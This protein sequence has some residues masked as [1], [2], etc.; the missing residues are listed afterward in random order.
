[1]LISV[2]PKALW[3]R[4]TRHAGLVDPSPP[5]AVLDRQD[6][7]SPD[8]MAG[9]IASFDDR[10]TLT[11]SWRRR[12]WRGPTCATCRRCSTSPSLRDGRAVTEVDDHAGGIRGV[13][14]MPYRFSAA[15]SDVRGPAPRR[16]EHN[17]AMLADWL[18]ASAAEV[19]ALLETGPLR[20]A[21]GI[22]P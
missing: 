20:A 12:G 10:R 4:L 19:D 7:R 2:D 9:W 21:P 3:H 14:R 11:P 16:G 8:A 6:R 13:V 17:A 5:G 1:M 15:T 22:D 18:T